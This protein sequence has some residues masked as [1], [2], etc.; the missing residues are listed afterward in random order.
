MSR[1]RVGSSVGGIILRNF[2][3]SAD[4]VFLVVHIIMLLRLFSPHDRFGCL[5]IRGVSRERRCGLFR[6]WSVEQ[7]QHTDVSALRHAMQ[8]SPPQYAHKEVRI[9]LVP[10]L[11]WKK[12]GR[13]HPATTRQNHSPLI[14][15]ARSAEDVRG[16]ELGWRAW[17]G[18]MKGLREREC[19]V[20]ARREASEQLVQRW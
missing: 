18:N 2:T 14:G 10:R 12:S 5:Q 15:D 1:D 9:R 11:Y 4:F 19:E 6:L 3:L 16:L 13:D 8:V 20:P 7:R 17:D